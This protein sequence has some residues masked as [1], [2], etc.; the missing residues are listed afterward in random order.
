MMHTSAELFW[1]TNSEV[2][3]GGSDYLLS[4]LWK[5]FPRSRREWGWGL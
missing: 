2:S 1:L 4:D 5:G 3:A